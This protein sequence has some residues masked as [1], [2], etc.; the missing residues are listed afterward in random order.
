MEKIEQLKKKMLN[1]REA[2]EIFKMNNSRE[3]IEEEKCNEPQHSTFGMG[4]VKSETRMFELTKDN[5]DEMR[6]LEQNM[7]DTHSAYVNEYV[8]SKR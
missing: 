5:I 1:A 3:L 4:V 7:R 8:N 6:R 2:Y